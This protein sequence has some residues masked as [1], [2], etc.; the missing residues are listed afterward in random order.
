MQLVVRSAVVSLLLGAAWFA[1]WHAGPP[2]VQASTAVVVKDVR[3]MGV[4]LGS[5]TSWGAEQLASNVIKNPGFEGNVDRSIVV[6]HRAE[7]NSFTEAPGVTGR[8]D[9]FWKGA[10]FQVRSGRNA[11]L[12]GTLESSRAK[13]PAGL[14]E[15]TA[16]SDMRGIESGSIIS[17][18][19]TDDASLPADWW[20]DQKPGA[21][22]EMENRDRRPESPGASSLRIHS[23]RGTPARVDS[24]LDAIGSRAGS[25][26]PVHGRWSLAFWARLERGSAALQ[27][28]FGRQKMKPFVDTRVPLGSA[29]RRFDYAF[30]ASGDAPPEM[31]DLRFE[32]AAPDQ[33]DV[34]L[35]DVELRSSADPGPFRHQAVEDLRYLHPAYLRDWEGQLGDT[36]DNRIAA[37]LAR[38]TSRYRPGPISEADFHYGLPEFLTL[39]AEVGASPWV[40]IPTTFSEDECGRLGSFL[41][42]VQQQHHFQEIL[43]EFGNENWNTLFRPAGIPDAATHGQVADRCFRQLRRAAGEIPLLT[44]INGQ[45]ANPTAAAAFASASGNADILAVAPYL[46][47]ALDTGTSLDAAFGQLFEADGGRLKGI[48]SAASSVHKETAVYEINL[49]TDGGT[50]KDNERMRITSGQASGTAIA[51]QMLDS[52]AAGVRRQCVYTLAGFDNNS[53]APGGHVRLWGIARDLA[54]GLRL[55]PSGLAIR[56]V[57]QAVHGDLMRS[58]ST[59]TAIRA[60][61]FRGAGRWSA[62]IASTS[63]ETKQV[64]VKFPA[65][66]ALPTTAYTFS[67]DSP[68]ATNEDEERVTIQAMK[69][70]FTGDTTQVQLPP[71]GLAALVPGDLQ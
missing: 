18:T 65:Q 13:G 47:R 7:G 43:V 29:W 39:A 45:H 59:D 16:A 63:P 70:T 32:V 41:A 40:V 14:P 53:A 68:A 69:V 20:F 49:H 3:R 21:A 10:A 1:F 51:V 24:Y 26:L 17:L 34:L 57:N 67:A 50:A 44:V 30:T 54:S 6:V 31:L 25:M 58:E 27:V 12:S 61:V 38:R 9:G 62:V 64:Q 19:R 71:Y 36:F 15:Y 5:W 8:P 11:G 42:G 60:Y 52:L 23:S 48:Q 37:P 2:V 35:D 22:F 55:R 46:L 33:G 56:L 66:S 4:N 28:S